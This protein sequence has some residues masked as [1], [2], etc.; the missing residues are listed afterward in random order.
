M[1]FSQESIET[2]GR[3]FK[4]ARIKSGCSQADLR[5]ALGLKSNQYVSNVERGLSAP[6]IKYMLAAAKVYKIRRPTLARVLKV[7]INKDIDR[8]ING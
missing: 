2:L 4:D 3:L 8:I 7:L 1:K 5:R 6:T